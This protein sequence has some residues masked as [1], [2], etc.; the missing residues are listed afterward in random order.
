MTNALLAGLAIAF[1]VHFG[2]IVKYDQVL[3]QEPNPWILAT[4]VALF[5][6]CLA[7]AAYNLVRLNKEAIDD[8]RN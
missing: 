3:I 8:H 6:G 2:L 1:L 5:V 4:E 7:L